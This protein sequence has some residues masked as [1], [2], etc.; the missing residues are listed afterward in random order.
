MIG[1]Y[2]G[3]VI[4]GEITVSDQQCFV[5]CAEIG[6]GGGEGA[7]RIESSLSNALFA[8]LYDGCNPPI[9]II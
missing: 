9:H 6:G 1:H 3:A 2:F 4:Q 8:H 5:F 7:Q